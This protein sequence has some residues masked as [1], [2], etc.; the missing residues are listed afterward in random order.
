MVKKE[1]LEKLKTSKV[2]KDRKW[3]YTLITWALENQTKDVATFQRRIQSSVHYAK[4][5]Y[6]EYWDNPRTQAQHKK[7]H[8]KSI[9]L[10]TNYKENQQNYRYERQIIQ[11][12]YR[13]G[14]LSKTSEKKINKILTKIKNTR[15]TKK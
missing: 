4:G 7:A 9:K 15:G 5:K 2:S 13:Q 8:A 14:E 1:L 6:Q 3:I 10:N 12:M 11:A